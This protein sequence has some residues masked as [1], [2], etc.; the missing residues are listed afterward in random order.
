MPA[1][2]LQPINLDNAA[3]SPLWPEARQAMLEALSLGNPSSTHAAG[4]SAKQALER[5]RGQIADLIAAKPAAVHFT[6]CATESNAW[7]IR[8]LLGANKRLS[9]ANKP[10]T[11]HVIISAIEH[12]SVLSAARRLELDGAISTTTLSVDAEGFVSS[13]DL[14][15]ALTGQTVL[16]SVMA[17]NGEIGTVQR[18]R[19]LAGVARSHQ[20]LFHTDAVAAAGYWPIDVKAW[21][22]DALTLSLNAC[23]GP[24][25]AAAL[26]VREGLRILPLLEGGGQERGGRSGTEPL[27]AAVGLGVAAEQAQ[28]RLSQGIAPLAALRDRLVRALRQGI[29]KIRINGNTQERLPQ[30]AHVC[31][32]G[33]SS[34]SLV[35]GLDQ[36]GVLAGL[37]SAC[38]AKAMRPS[39]VLKAIGLSDE[40]AAGAL[41]LSL[42]WMTTESDV[43]Q[44]AAIIA[45][46]VEPL[47]RVSALT[48][49]IR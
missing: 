7:A 45:K 5:A 29:E 23:H 25:G 33:V 30:N 22:V 28:K 1:S 24:M 43:D 21:G 41:V 2:P 35:L 18:I 3:A 42:N 14:E 31:I 6:S 49:R 48:A 26:Y 47:R 20:A 40:E 13:G 34:E 39:H 38:N 16:V 19:E 32:E 17:A 44:A 10:S 9:G 11:P 4:R 46:V 12:P 8:G 15:K 37:G 36:A 27:A